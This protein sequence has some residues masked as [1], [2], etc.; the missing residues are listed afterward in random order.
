MG[1]WCFWKKGQEGGGTVLQ[2][3]LDPVNSPSPMLG[4]DFGETQIQF[5]PGPGRV[6]I[7]HNFLYLLFKSWRKSILYQ[8]LFWKNFRKLDLHMNFTWGCRIQWALEGYFSS[9]LERNLLDVLSICPD[10]PNS[11]I[12]P[13]RQ[14]AV[15]TYSSKCKRMILRKSEKNSAISRTCHN[16]CST[17][18]IFKIFAFLK[19][20]SKFIS[21]F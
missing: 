4:R 7:S 3:G 1:A 18:P 11:L 8:E 12:R 16:F 5:F 17:G 19:M 20:A 15:T 10:S 13:W 21:S 9:I 6:R 14:V 2:N